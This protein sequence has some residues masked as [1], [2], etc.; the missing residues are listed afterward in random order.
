MKTKEQ[1]KAYNKE[2]FARPEV[3]ERERIKNARPEMVEKRRAYK[4][5]NRGKTVNKESRRR[6]WDKNAPTREK[7]LLYR[8]GLTKEVFDVMIEKQEGACAICLVVPEKRLH[9]DHCHTT[10]KVRGLLC[11]NCNMALGLFKDNTKTLERA[12]KYLK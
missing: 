10:N 2:Y 3:I 8:Y 7:K 5:T 4:K 12:I 11:S 9:V 6:N 1:I